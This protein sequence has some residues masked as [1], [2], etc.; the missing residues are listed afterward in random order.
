MARLRQLIH[1]IHRRS[2]W[3]VP[4]RVRSRS[5]LA[6]ACFL[7]L[8]AFGCSRSDDRAV[9]DRSTL[10]VLYP[11]DERVLGAEGRGFA[12]SSISVCGS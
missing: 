11:F 2:P 4:P 9:S 12:S 1:E 5:L 10:T 3:Q 8:A 7:A 6:F